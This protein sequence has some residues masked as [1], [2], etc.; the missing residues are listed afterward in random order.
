MEGL[1]RKEKK[2]IYFKITKTRKERDFCQ[3]ITQ[4][5]ARSRLPINEQTPA[6]N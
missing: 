3:I 1:K 5:F 2:K 6:E 4:I